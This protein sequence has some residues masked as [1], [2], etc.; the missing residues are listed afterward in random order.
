M[1]VWE[2]MERKWLETHNGFVWKVVGYCYMTKETIYFADTFTNIFEAKEAIEKCE[3][4]LPTMIFR[5]YLAEP[6][7]QR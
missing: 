4:N 1:Y 7:V 5:P 2:I 3:K 6:S